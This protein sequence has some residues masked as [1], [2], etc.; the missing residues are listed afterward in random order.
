MDKKFSGLTKLTSAELTDLLY[1]TDGSYPYG[2]RS[3]GAEVG[4][5]IS[6]IMPAATDDIEGG[7]FKASSEEIANLESGVV[8][9]PKGAL[10]IVEDKGF[11]AVTETLEEV[12][13]NDEIII[14]K[15]GEMFKV[16]VGDFIGRIKVSSIGTG[17]DG[18]LTKGTTSNSFSTDK[19]VVRRVVEGLSGTDNASLFTATSD[20]IY[21]FFIYRP[22]DYTWQTA[23]GLDFN[24]VPSRYM[25]RYTGN[26]TDRPIDLSGRDIHHTGEI[27]S[28]RV[29][30][31]SNQSSQYSTYSIDILQITEE[32]EDSLLFGTEQ[33]TFGTEDLRFG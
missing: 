18:I 3:A 19:F 12:D 27:F 16:S 6:S 29:F 10:D 17:T 20:S 30:D 32:T 15:G 2:N 1:C 11:D 8:L 26:S 25:S 22:R 23:T 24:I 7:A 14:E 5:V 4:K 31:P 33:L 21:I 28:D 9:T 13:K